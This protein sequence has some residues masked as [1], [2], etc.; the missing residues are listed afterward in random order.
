VLTKWQKIV[1]QLPVIL[2][3]MT[4]HSKASDAKSAAYGE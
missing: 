3:K 1:L 2:T 4:A